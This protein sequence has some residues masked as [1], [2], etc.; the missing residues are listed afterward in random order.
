MKLPRK[1]AATNPLDFPVEVS[2]LFER[3]AYNPVRV[4]EA[5]KGFETK[6]KA[7]GARMVLA[8]WKAQ[9]CRHPE[10][11]KQFRSLISTLQFTNPIKEGDSW[12]FYMQPIATGSSVVELVKGVVSDRPTPSMDEFWATYKEIQ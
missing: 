5:G 6:G 8:R 3:A 12:C 10:V 1:Q 9:M 4:P 2:M 11:L 7:F